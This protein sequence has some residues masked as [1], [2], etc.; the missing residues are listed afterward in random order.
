MKAGEREFVR[1]ERRLQK[2]L[3]LTFRGAGVIQ[4]KKDDKMNMAFRLSNRIGVL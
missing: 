2:V 1:P 4:K 3:I